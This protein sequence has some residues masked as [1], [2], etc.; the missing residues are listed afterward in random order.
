[1]GSSFLIPPQTQIK[2]LVECLVQRPT[3][4]ACDNSSS[5]QPQSGTVD[6][7]LPKVGNDGPATKKRK[8]VPEFLS[9]PEL[10]CEKQFT[11]KDLLR[12]RYTRGPFLSS[13]RSLA[14]KFE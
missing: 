12:H 10:G 9:C 11:K 13:Q 14:N 3:S 2:S 5:E 7:V 6:S 1:M 8:R 4:E